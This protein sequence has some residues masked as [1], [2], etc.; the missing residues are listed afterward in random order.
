MLAYLPIYNGRGGGARTLK[1]AGGR[2]AA[3]RRALQGIQHRAPPRQRNRLACA[4]TCPTRGAEAAGGRLPHFHPLRISS[5]DP[6]KSS[7]AQRRARG[8]K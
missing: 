6:Y 5:L 1:K 4:P 3:V 2:A 8:S 7:G